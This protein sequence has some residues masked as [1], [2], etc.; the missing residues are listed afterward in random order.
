MGIAPLWTM[1]KPGRYFSKLN[2]KQLS[3][4][5]PF[6]FAVLVDAGNNVE[7]NTNAKRSQLSKLAPEFVKN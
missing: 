4:I 2:E 5:A 6:P 7:N 1:I 3:P